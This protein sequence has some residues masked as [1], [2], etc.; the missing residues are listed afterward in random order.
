M[1]FVQG[2][3]G[4]GQ[5]PDAGGEAGQGGAD[6][7]TQPM[8]GPI[9]LNTASLAVLYTLPQMTEEAAQGIV[10]YR[11]NTPFQSRG[12]LLRL[13]EI[14]QAVFNAI[15]ERVTVL[16]DRFTVR[17]LGMS[18]SVSQSTGR[19]SDLGVHLTATLD[20]STGRCRIVRLR[21]DN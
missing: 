10:S 15:I 12:D 3:A 13:P 17:S 8:E 4:A 14:T 16:S 19:E 1:Q 7:N 2:G 11:E 5:A 20:R 9:N 18:R 6:E 21:Q